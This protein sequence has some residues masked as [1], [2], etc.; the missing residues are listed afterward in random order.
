MSRRNFEAVVMDTVYAV[1][2]VEYVFIAH[3]LIYIL[4]KYWMRNSI[5]PFYDVCNCFIICHL[6]I[7]R[8]LAAALNYRF[9][10]S[11]TSLAIVIQYS[12]QEEESRNV[13]SELIHYNHKVLAIYTHWQTH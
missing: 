6:I 2:H 12:L 11:K 5:S 13:S 1:I 10:N 4:H 8:I 3:I 7:T 9:T